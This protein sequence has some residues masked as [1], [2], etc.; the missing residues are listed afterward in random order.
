MSIFARTPESDAAWHQL[1]RNVAL[2]PDAQRSPRKE[3]SRELQLL[4]AGTRQKKKSETSLFLIRA[5]TPSPFRHSL[6]HLTD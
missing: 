6:A 4:F 5:N 2:G 1:K 3:R